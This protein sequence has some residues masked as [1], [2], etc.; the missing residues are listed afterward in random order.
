M[1]LVFATARLV[2]ALALGPAPFA[3]AGPSGAAIQPGLA[4]RAEGRPSFFGEVAPAR[5]DEALPPPCLGDVCQP[6]VSVPGYEPRYGRS[7]RTELVA[8]ALE[9][10]R[11]EPFA[12]IGWALVT[13]GIR[14][15]YRPAAFE[16]PNSGARGWGA[17]FLRFRL[18]MDAY[19]TLI[20]PSRSR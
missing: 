5:A 19:N 6:R 10:A 4:M 18:R 9:R 3:V 13:T 14:L 12:T 11:L 1:L 16:G 2:A 17:V 20:F 15:D 7:R 8:L